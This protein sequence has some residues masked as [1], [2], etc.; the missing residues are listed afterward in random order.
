MLDSRPS[1]R[2][3]L[4]L[5]EML[6]VIAIIGILMAL[7]LPAIQ[8]ARE[9]ARRM[10]C[11]S[12]VRQL[13]LAAHH[14]E[15]T[16]KKFPPG[17]LGE[18][19]VR[20][21]MVVTENSYV[22]HL[23]FLMPFMELDEIYHAWARKRDLGV[24]STIRVS[25]DPRYMRWSNG[26]V[27]GDSLW[28]DHQYKIE[29]LLCP[30]DDAYSNSS[31]TVTELRTT[32]TTG[33]V[34]SFSEPSMLGRTNYLGSAGRLGVGVPSRDAFRGIFYNRSETRTAHITDGLSQT[35]M[36]GEVTGQFSDPVLAKG[37]LRSISWNAGPQWTE[38]HR[39][40]YNYARHKRVEKFSSM[41]PM[42]INFAFADGSTKP[43]SEDI[44]GDLL[45]A[46]SSMAG[47]E[48]AETA[49]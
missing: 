48:V 25:G 46:L 21:G 9:V 39:P 30:S 14:Y 26:A 19:P 10:S 49:D 5:I 41:H 16:H 23:V 38:W 31:S 32:T 33:M 29:V 37:R 36:F 24:R 2:D 27:N 4:S 12:H 1:I 43:L 28:S 6:V 47:Q 42:V 34:H 45:V 8:A 7:A 13:A 22:G 20:A 3:G 40:I 15:A 18:T 35:I 44:D 17:Y 11:S